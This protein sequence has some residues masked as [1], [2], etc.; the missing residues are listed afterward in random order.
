MSVAA[1]RLTPNLFGV[2]FGLA[3]LA[4]CWAL[5]AA[6]H[7]TPQWIAN[8][9]WILTAAVW[10]VILVAYLRNV[11]AGGRLRTELDDAT[12]GPFVILITI[13]PMFL[14]VALAQWSRPA[15]VTVFLVAAVGT[16]LIGGWL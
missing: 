13:V 5:A 4:Q 16:V 9:L 8:A 15:G 3:G 10:L 1:R 6:T 12:F 2:S 14:G 11:I 7:V